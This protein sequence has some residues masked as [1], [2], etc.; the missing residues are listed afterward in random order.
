MRYKQAMPVGARTDQ[1]RHSRGST[2]AS[3]P[4]LRLYLQDISGQC[5]SATNLPRTQS[6]LGST[7][8][9]HKPLLQ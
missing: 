9:M 2:R 4:R 5:A 6:M 3:L 8:K 7:C 1:L